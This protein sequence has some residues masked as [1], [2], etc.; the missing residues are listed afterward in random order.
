M[1][2]TRL[3]EDVLEERLTRWGKEIPSPTSVV[4]LTAAD[5][6]RRAETQAKRF[7]R[8][9]SVSIVALI[10][11]SISLLPL[12]TRTQSVAKI[13]KIDMKSSLAEEPAPGKT[14]PI[15][16][17]HPTPLSPPRRSELASRDSSVTVSDPQLR[18][19]WLEAKQLE[20]RTRILNEWLA[21]NP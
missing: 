4:P 11:F 1:N 5:L 8:N 20:V 17:I 2:N 19:A 16:S 12:V 18:R 14:L 15:E 3:N 21:A 9:L 7:Q 10:A 6:Q 13:A